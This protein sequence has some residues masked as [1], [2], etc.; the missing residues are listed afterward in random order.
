MADNGTS[1]LNLPATAA[2]GDTDVIPLARPSG[3]TAPGAD[4]GITGAS[5]KA[6]AGGFTTI[7]LNQYGTH[8]AFSSQAGLNAYLLGKV[9]GGSPATTAPTVSNPT[10]TVTPTVTSPTFTAA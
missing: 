1:I 3:T 8:P 2:L 5:L 9:S 6:L 7:N 10:F 4:L